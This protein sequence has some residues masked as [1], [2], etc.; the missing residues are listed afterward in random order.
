MKFALG[1]LFTRLTGGL[2]FREG[3]AS[4]VLITC[5]FGALMGLGSQAR[6]HGFGS[7][8]TELVYEYGSNGRTLETRQPFSLRGGY[9]VPVADV[10]VEYTRFSISQ[11]SPLVQVRRTHHEALAWARRFFFQDWKLWPYLAVGVGAQFETIETTLGDETAKSTGSP[12]PVFGGVMGLS[13]SVWRGL[14]VQLEGGLSVSSGFSPNPK[15]GFG[16]HVGWGF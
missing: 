8:G 13:A 15:P 14:E 7:V 3:L 11:G 9:R 16:F 5:G 2:V 4:L 6:A 12:Q 1:T 10:Y